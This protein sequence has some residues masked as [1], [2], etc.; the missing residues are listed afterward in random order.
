[1]VTPCP[2]GPENP[3][4]LRLVSSDVSKGQWD[5]RNGML[6]RVLKYYSLKITHEYIGMK[7]YEWDLFGGI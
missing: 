1:M 3:R 6:I 5:F 4:L 7:W 2:I